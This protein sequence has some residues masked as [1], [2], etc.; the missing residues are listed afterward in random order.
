M[1]AYVFFGVI[2]LTVAGWPHSR[3]QGPGRHT[4]P[5]LFSSPFLFCQTYM[6]SSIFLWNTIVYKCSQALTYQAIFKK[7]VVLQK[8]NCVSRIFHSTAVYSTIGNWQP[9]L[10]RKLQFHCICCVV[11]ERVNQLPKGPHG[12]AA[13]TLHGLIADELIGS[14]SLQPVPDECRSK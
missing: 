11:C 3:A 12:D 14:T 8:E 6:C 4:L 7:T 9:I 10:P 1:Y 5:P 2:R 13:C